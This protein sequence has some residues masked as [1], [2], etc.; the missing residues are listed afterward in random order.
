MSGNLQKIRN[1]GIVA[2]IDAGKTT[3]TERILYYAGKIYRIGSVDEG[4]ATMDY[5]VQ[6]KEHGITIQSAATFFKWRDY[7]FNL[8]DT[9][10][11]VDF[12]IEV[13]RSIRV[14]DGII[15]ILDA[16]AGVQPQTETVYRQ[17]LKYK[18]PT[19]FFVNKMDKLGANFEH[20]LDSIKERLLTNP[21]PI[22]LPFGKE[23]EFSGVVDLIGMKL[24][25]WI[26][27]DGS[28]Y[29]YNELPV[30][31]DKDRIFMLEEIASLDEIFM[32]KYL[33][34]SYTVDDVYSA[35]R[36]I[37]I[38]GVGSPVLCGSAVKNIGI[39]PLI[40]AVINF[41]PSPLDR[42][43]QRSFL[44]TQDVEKEM[45]VDIV[46][47]SSN[48]LALCFKV[49]YFPSVG[50]VSFIRVYSGKVVENDILYNSTKDIKERANRIIKMHANYM[51]EIKEINMGEIGAIVGL[52]KTVT[53]DTLLSD[54]SKR[55]VLESIYV[56]EP[57]IFT[58]I[59]AS[60][61]ADE[62]KLFKALERL[63]EEDPTFKYKI[64]ED[65]GQI[66]ISGMGELH[67]DIIKDRIQR[68]YNLRIY[69]GKPQVE[70]KESI[71]KKS[72]GEYNFYRQVGNK[73]QTAYVKVEIIP[74]S[75]GIK[76]FVD[77]QEIPDKIVP[78]VREGIGE[79]LA[80][81]VL[82]GFPCT[83]VKVRVVDAK[84]DKDFS[85]PLAFKVAAFEATKL[86]MSNSNPVLL[87]PVMNVEIITPEEYM[88]SVINDIQ[89]RNGEV[90]EISIYQSM[91]NIIINKITALVP[92][93]E[94]FGYSTVLRSLTQGRGNFNMELYTYKEVP[95]SIQ[96]NIIL[97]GTL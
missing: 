67:L 56:P 38:S 10:G 86:A 50:K 8:I 52:K 31:Y 13:E 36:R 51:E 82:A 41:L 22:Q 90:Q 49:S 40:D 26:S 74:I 5:M 76:I 63:A 20:C 83:R 15:V 28:E 97:K 70:F 72:E 24:I 75:E 79:A 18:V 73:L 91:G 48:L 46:E 68:E 44:I 43:K 84:Y 92:L 23:D 9:P 32:D 69:S 53:G 58:A 25:Q 12:T 54:D 19:I 30:S 71:T 27:Q 34:S 35:L 87:E 7:E 59:E 21:I 80:F 95:L 4:T 37:T 14:L 45:I 66:I 96:E 3:T 47:N 78:Q 17:A 61:R 39:Q 6:E 60:S 11:H 85:T 89:S 57:V 55:I 81:G 77:T 2:H 29:V 65:T 62:E 42:S 88:G 1:I 16:S 94:I 33:S 93:R 64:N